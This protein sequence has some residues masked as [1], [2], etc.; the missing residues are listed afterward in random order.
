MVSDRIGL[1]EPEQRAA[2]P[3]APLLEGAERVRLVRA[4]RRRGRR[5]AP[6]ARRRRSARGRPSP[7]RPGRVSNRRSSGRSCFGSS[8]HSSARR[9]M[10]PT[11]A[12]LLPVA[13][14]K[15]LDGSSGA[16]ERPR[17][18]ART[19]RCVSIAHRNSPPSGASQL[20]M[21][22]TWLA[23]QQ[24]GAEALLQLLLGLAL[25]DHAGL[26]AGGDRRWPGPPASTCPSRRSGAVKAC[27][28][29]VGS[30]RRTQAVRMAER[31]TARSASPT[32]GKVATSSSS[33]R[34]RRAARRPG[35]G[36]SGTAGNV[37]RPGS[38]SRPVAAVVA[39]RRQDACRPAGASAR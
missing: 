38:S 6:S 21:A 24:Q 22:I 37:D 3:A 27:I 17:M 28:G 1:A 18:R 29:A 36:R 23:G 35:S 31:A 26:A 7:P 8:R 12:R 34:Q 13:V 30:E 33:S 32:K 10:S 4:G 20:S 2:H 25:G 15:A 14:T 9:V 11:S 5:A 39:R 19:T 16:S